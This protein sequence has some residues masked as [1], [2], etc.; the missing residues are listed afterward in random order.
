MRNSSKRKQLI[1][2]LACVV[3]LILLAGLATIIFKP[4]TIIAVFFFLALPS[5]FLCW[6]KKKNYKKIVLASITFGVLGGMAWAFVAEFNNV[7]IINYDNAA[8]NYHLIGKTPVGNFIWAFLIPFF[9]ISFYEHF[10][11]DERR[12]RL[13]KHCP[14][15]LIISAVL[16]IIPI[17]KLAR[18]SS[19]FQIHYA[20]FILGLLAS[21]PLIYLLRAKPLLTKKIA[22]AGL[23]FVFVN[24]IF[25]LA[26][27]YA[28]LWSFPGFYIGWIGS[29]VLRFPIEELIFWIIPSAAVF[30]IC[31]ELCFD[32]CA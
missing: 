5:L 28:G 18:T 20:Y 22:I 30:L 25:E 17:V 14:L 7:W 10:L 31:Y 27:L 6:R 4:Q 24:M 32:D 16:F 8:L 29:G 19:L 13:S 26:A 15:A 3:A 23:F 12:Y 2:D 1:T 11:D 9:T 21:V